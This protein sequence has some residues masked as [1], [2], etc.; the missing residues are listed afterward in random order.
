MYFLVLRKSRIITVFQ[1]IKS[2]NVSCFDKTM[3]AVLSD[4]LKVLLRIIQEL[5]W[6]RKSITDGAIIWRL[7]G[8]H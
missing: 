1:I 4:L 3:I 7:L 6:E 8:T 2:S 5:N